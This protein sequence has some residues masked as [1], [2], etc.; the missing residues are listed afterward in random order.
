MFY[1]RHA[2]TFV[3]TYGFPLDPHPGRAAQPRHRSDM[4]RFTDA[5]DRHRAKA[6]ESVKGSGDSASRKQLVFALRENMAQP[7][8]LA[9][10]ME[11]TNGVVAGNCGRVALR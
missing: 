10:D 9:Y 1:G 5:M 4:R 2:F 3:H 8:F 7:N 11:S 6:R